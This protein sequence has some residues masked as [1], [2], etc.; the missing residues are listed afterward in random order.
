[1][2]DP[3]LGAMAEG[4][5][6]WLDLLEQQ[7]DA[8]EAGF[9]SVLEV[10]RVVGNTPLEANTRRGLGIARLGLGRRAEGRAAFRSAVELLATGDAT[11]DMELIATLHWIALAT[12]AVDGRAAVRLVGAVDAVRQSGKMT[13]QPSELELHRRFEQPLIDALGEDEWVREQAAGATLTLEEAIELA[14]RLAAPAPEGS[15]ESD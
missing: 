14:R 9:R 4:N 12:E 13:A 7:Y 3:I 2:D 10:V 5:A 15:T 1:M 8:A 11:R 6:S